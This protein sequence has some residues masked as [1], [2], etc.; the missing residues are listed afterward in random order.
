MGWLAWLKVWIG[1]GLGG[2][3]GR[4]EGWEGLTIYGWSGGE[5][6]GKGG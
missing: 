2:F 5:V 4:S 3:D 6:G 1:L